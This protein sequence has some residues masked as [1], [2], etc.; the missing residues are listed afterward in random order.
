MKKIFLMTA[1]ITAFTLTACSGGSK[2]DK[3]AEAAKIDISDLNAPE[4][5]YLVDDVHS[6][7]VFKVKHMGVGY[8]YGNFNHMG[9]YVDLNRENPAESSMKFKVDLRTVDT[10][11]AKRDDHLR[12][13]DFFDAKK[14]PYAVFKSTSFSK[15]GDKTYKV[16][17]ELDIHG[18]TQPVSFTYT[19]TGYMKEDPWGKERIGAETS[20][21]VNRSDFGITGIDKKSPGAVSDKVELMIAVEAVR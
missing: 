15:T 16:E 12:N 1:L 10:A 13:P 5:A 4:G 20:F 11:N 19:E 17:G 7:V 6:F 8:A 2:S 3:K 14:F 18:Q 9:G 21:V